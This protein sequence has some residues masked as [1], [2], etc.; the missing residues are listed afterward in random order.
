MNK[1]QSNERRSIVWRSEACPSDGDPS[2][3]RA[4]RARPLRQ[5]HWAAALLGAAVFGDSAVE[6]Y[7][8]AFSN[9]A[10]VLPLGAAA[11]TLLASLQGSATRPGTGHAGRQL[12]YGTSMAIG[13]LGTGFH[14]YNVAKRVGG[15][16]WNNVFY[17]APL[18]APAALTLSGLLGWC[19]DRLAAADAGAPPATLLGLPAGRVLAGVTSAGLIGTIGEAALM[20]LRGAYHNPAMWLPVTL[21]GVAAATMAAATVGRS[22]PRPASKI[23]LRVTAVLGLAGTAFHCYG[24][25]RHMG[26]WRNW[27]QNVLDGPPVPAP[28]AF[29]GLALAGLA[30]L[31]LIERERRRGDRS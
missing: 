12:T 24:V 15:W 10:M 30:A 31:A 19:A 2:G 13:M 29:T 3:Q 21:P 22:R 9:P 28:P 18:G 4:A 20:H 26:G 16:R 5:L 23:W 27:G 1:R 25:S 14:V 8:G 17:G 7:R 6:H 11:G